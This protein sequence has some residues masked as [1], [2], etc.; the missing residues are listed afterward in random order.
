MNITVP[1]F[2]TYKQVTEWMGWSHATILRKVKQ[3]CFPI[4]DFGPTDKKFNANE[5]QHYI[6]GMRVGNFSQGGAS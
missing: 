4:Y 1:V 3:G 6:D 2:M 5:I